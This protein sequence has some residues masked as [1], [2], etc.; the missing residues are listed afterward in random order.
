MVQRRFFYF[1]FETGLRPLFRTRLMGDAE[2]SDKARATRRVRPVVPRQGSGRALLLDTDQ[3]EDDIEGRVWPVVKSSARATVRQ[4]SGEPNTVPSSRPDS[5]NGKARASRPQ[6]LGA[7]G[8][9]LSSAANRNVELDTLTMNP[10]T[11][12]V[13][14]ISSSPGCGSLERLDSAAQRDTSRQ[15]EAVRAAAIAATRR[16]LVHQDL[17]TEQQAG[18]VVRLSSLVL[19]FHRS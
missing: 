10:H 1:F 16:A 9:N 8:Q 5:A 19:G 15:S 7:G 4:P 18:D 13:S 2:V 11:G 14:S 12:S 3:S 6:E 17:S